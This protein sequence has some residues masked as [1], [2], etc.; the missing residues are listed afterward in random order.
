MRER[1]IIRNEMLAEH[2]TKA[3]LDS[4]LTVLIYEMPQKSSVS[5]QLSA[6]IGSV[7][8]RFELDGVVTELPAGVAHFLEHKLFESEQGDAFTLFAKTGASANAFYL[9]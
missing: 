8:K 4:G 2:Y 7:T 3:V 6:A 1:R 9:I 5:V